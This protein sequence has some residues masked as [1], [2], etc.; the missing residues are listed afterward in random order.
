MSIRG[1]AGQS[2][3][4]AGLFKYRAACHVAYTL[5]SPSLSSTASYIPVEA[6]DG[7]AARNIPLCV[8]TSASTVGLPRESMIWRPTT[9][10]IAGGD[11]FCS[12]SACIEQPYN[13][14]R[15]QGGFA[16]CIAA[17]IELTTPMNGRHGGHS[18]CKPM[19]VGPASRS[20]ST[21]TMYE[22]GS[23]G[24]CLTVRLMTSS[25]FLLR[26]ANARQLF[27]SL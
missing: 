19:R 6:P 13:V 22:M 10:T 25:I 17:L 8:C 1:W 23:S 27:R 12:C 18:P 15:L 16:H 24:F 9:F 5:L 14:R 11:I 21:L 2:G 3:P 7:T 20:S 4:K 26:S